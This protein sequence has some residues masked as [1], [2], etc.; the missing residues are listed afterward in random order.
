V[1]RQTRLFFALLV[2]TLGCDA[3]L[4]ESCHDDSCTG[5]VAATTTTGGEGGLAPSGL[6]SAVDAILQTNCSGPCHH[7]PPANGAPFPLL[8]YADTQADY[9]GHPRW[10]H[11]RRAIQTDALPPQMPQGSWPMDPAN[12]D[13]LNAWFAT[14]DPDG[15]GGESPI[16]QCEGDPNAGS[17]GGGGAGAGGAGTGGTGGSTTTGAGAGGTGGAGGA[18]GAGGN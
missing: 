1:H 17:T 6:P 12:L 2:T 5:T 13:V 7:A 14:C 10:W 11:M 9:A 4:E 18:G 16:N 15:A 3:S 8:T